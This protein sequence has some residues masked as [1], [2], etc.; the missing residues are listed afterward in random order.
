MYPHRANPASGAFVAHQVGQLRR[1]GHRVDVLHIL[2]YRS[3]W[4]YLTAAIRV[5]RATRRVRYDL[6]HAHYG[7]SGFPA[8]FRVRTPLVVTLHGSDALV[9][10]LQPWISRLVCRFADEVIVTSRQIAAG[11]PGEVIP[12]GVDLGLFTPR[13]RR[14][15]RER[16]GLPRDKTLILFPF[17]PRRKV[18]RYDL[19]RTVLDRLNDR[20][21]DSEL[22][23]VR[24]VASEEMPWYYGAA[25]A[26]LVCS[27]SEGS[28]TSVKEALAS[29]TPVVSTDVGD[30]RELIQGVRGAEI[31][32]QD[33]SS[34]AEGL[35]RVLYHAGRFGFKGRDAARPYDQSLVAEA[36]LRVYRRVVRGG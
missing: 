12:C 17:D 2:G 9:G 5:F 31:C 6:T 3:K 15:S 7:L 30:V 32:R 21:W 11:F 36:V 33:A 4:N 34:L 35:E 14:E 24:A 19:A 18:K 8:L 16:L 10:R 25:D 20:G 13:D 23:V 29:N 22:V 1:L 27:D 26:L 28:P